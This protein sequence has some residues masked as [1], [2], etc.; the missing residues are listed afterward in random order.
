[1]WEIC[2]S[3][4]GENYDAH[5]IRINQKNGYSFTRGIMDFK[6]AGYLY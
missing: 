5:K 4:K 3:K 6:L 2:M 1:M